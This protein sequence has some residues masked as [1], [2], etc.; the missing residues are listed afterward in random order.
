MRAIGYRRISKD[1]NGNGHSL[2]AQTS[3]IE[4]ACAARGWELLGIEEDI[5]GGGSTRNRPGLERALAMLDAGKADVLVVAKLDR[6]SRSVSDFSAMLGK[7]P[8]QLL[9]LDLGVDLTSPYGEMVATV[10]SAMAQLERRLVSER[11]KAA[12]AQARAE[13][14]KL[15]NPSFTPAPKRVVTRIR[16]LREQGLS[17][18]QIADKLNQ[19]G[20]ATPQ[21]GKHWQAG[22]V[23]SVLKRSA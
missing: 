4:Q 21:G 15:G 10:V 11:T 7:Y 23:A 13:G 6:L 1:A 12:L 19:A 2:Q 16:K 20:T 8:K 5:Q 9:V 17:L 18:R 3:A 22:S 14:R